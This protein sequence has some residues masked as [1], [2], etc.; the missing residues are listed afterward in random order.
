[1]RKFNKDKYL[2]KLKIKRFFRNNSRYFY[3]VLLCLLCGFLGIYFT[4]SKFFISDEQAVIRT[5]VGD[6]TRGDIV[7]NIYEDGKKVKDAPRKYNGY[8]LGSVTCT[9]GKAKWSDDDWHLTLE[10]IETRAKC[11]LYFIGITDYE[12]DYT[13]SEQ[14]VVIPKTGLYRLET[15]GSQGGSGINRGSSYAYR[16][17]G[18]GAYATG[19]ISL[20]K[21]DKLYV[22]V[23]GGGDIIID[24]VV[25]N[26]LLTAGYNGGGSGKSYANGGGATHIAT[27]SGLLTTLENNKDNILIVAGGG[28]GTSADTSGTGY[29]LGGSAGGITGQ[30]GTVSKVVTD[31]SAGV[32]GTQTTGYLFGSGYDATNAAKSSSGGGGGYYGG[33]IGTVC[34]SS[35][36]CG[37]GGSSYVGNP[38]LTT[39]TM[40]CYNCK[41]S[42]DYSTKTETTTCNEERPTKN[43][44]KKGNGYAK[45]T[46]IPLSI[47]YYADNI[48]QEN[49]LSKNL[50]AFSEIS[51]EKSSKITW[52]KDNWNYIINDYQE[53]DACKISFQSSN[54]A[55]VLNQLDSTDKCPSLNEDSTITISNVESTAGYLCSAPDTYGTSYYY[56]G[57][58]TN[59]YVYFAGFYWRII[60]VNGDESVRIIYDGTSSHKNGESSGD[61]QIGTS[62]FNS[63]Y[64]DNAYVGYMYGTPSSATYAETHANINDSTMKTYLENWYKT[65]II[66]KNYS[67]YVVDNIFCSDRTL[68]IGTGIGQ[69]YTEYSSVSQSKNRIFTCPNKNDTFTSNDTTNGNGLLTYPIGLI[70]VDEAVLAGGYSSAN[71]NY[72]LYTGQLYWTMSPNIYDSKY[73]NVACNRYI[74]TNGTVLYANTNDH[75]NYKNGVKPV[76]NL[77]SDVLK[78]G[79]GTMENPFHF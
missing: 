2:R 15:W 8:T 5:T 78:N 52:D 19:V 54:I 64:N 35:S 49:I 61:R 28:G 16:Q 73:S 26:E 46:Y 29:C 22:D 32:G 60:R 13:G 47:E 70:S 9:S 39:K 17:G 51:C 34:S 38:L 24:G 31:C 55:A 4:Y 75:V 20:K 74:N 42:T 27:R 67:R 12:F 37:G 48:K 3:I 69:T 43:C 65:N 23:G 63:N 6:F 77:K 25:N 76:I 10:N 33:K 56:R 1:M 66:D 72:Y 45:I 50:Y 58:V 53:N 57:N 30:S 44:A 40:H 71:S 79:D 14:E 21:G 59:N 41:T 7:L 11:N 62:A 68:S 18:Y 36:A